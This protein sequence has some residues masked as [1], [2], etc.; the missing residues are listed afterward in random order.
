MDEKKPKRGP[1]IQ[2]FTALDLSDA[3]A[4]FDLLASQ[5][6]SLAQAV[7]HKTPNETF[8]VDGGANLYYAL[9]WISQIHGAIQGQH[10]R[11]QLPQKGDVSATGKIPQLPP[12][13]K[14]KK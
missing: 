10:N 5:M 4:S 7:A 6:N 8:M 14:R 3:A 9:H 13:G 11:A 1:R 12:R 2:A